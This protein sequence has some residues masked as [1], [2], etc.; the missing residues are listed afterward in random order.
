MEAISAAYIVDTAYGDATAS[1]VAQQQA[2]YV[3]FENNAA[4]FYSAMQAT[5]YLSL[6]SLWLPLKIILWYAFTYKTKKRFDFASFNN[7]LDIRTFAL[8][9]TRI[10]YEFEYYRKNI[11]ITNSDKVN[12]THYYDNIYNLRNDGIFL[13]YLYVCGS[14]LLWLRIMMLFKLTRFL[15]PLVKMIENM[16]NDIAI[17]MVLFVIELVMF[18]SIG[19]L[20]FNSITNYSSM[21]DA[22]KT[23]FSTA[24][25][26][27]DFLILALNDKSEKLG[28]AYLI[29]FMI[30]NNILILN[31]LIAV[32][33]SNYALLESKKLVLY[34]NEILALRNM[35]EYDKNWSAI[36]STFPP[37]SIIATAFTPFIIFTKKSEKLSSILF[38]IEYIPFLSLITPIYIALNLILIPFG[39]IKGNFLNLQ[40]ICRKKMEIS[41][42]YRILRFFIFF[43]FGIPIL[44]LNLCSDLV[45]FIIHCYQ[46]KLHYRKEKIKTLKVSKETFKLVH[47]KVKREFRNHAKIISPKILAAHARDKML[48]MKYLQALIFGESKDIVWNSAQTALNKVNE[49][50]LIKQILQAVSLPSGICIENLL[51]VME[52]LK[53]TSK[54]KSLISIEDDLY[55]FIE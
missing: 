12:G 42:Q 39:Y 18:A 27:F 45:V 54:I 46:K 34:I 14:A 47:K 32:L 53:V 37:F 51:S 30:T 11:S 15:G 44:L 19:V 20:L 4:T 50:V 43:F 3:I 26:N 36:V 38:H 22:M 48:I 28:T 33:S 17:F 49:Y 24:L 31:L 5:I 1:T 41:I 7:F 10:V 40:Q 29:C 13:S 25:G 23:L 52:E 6:I 2:L 16:L 21:Y 8:F 9:L 55:C 35:L